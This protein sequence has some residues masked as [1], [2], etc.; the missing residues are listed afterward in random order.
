MDSTHNLN[1]DRI[2][3]AWATLRAHSDSGNALHPEAYRL[4]FADPEFLT[5]RETRGVR[6]QLEMLK[7]DL[8][9]DAQR[10]QNTIVVY[11][12]ARFLPPDEAAALLAAAETAGDAEAIA[13]AQLKV[14][15][16]RYYEQ[17]RL[18]ARLVAT[19]SQA[20]PEDE[21]LYICTGG[22]PGIMEAANRGA[23]EAGA[24][25]VGLNIALPH[26][27]SG[28]RF[29]TPSLSFKFHYFALRKM[30]FMMR[31]K[32]LVAF[33]GGF[34]TLDELFEVLTLVQTGKSKRVPIVLFGKEFWSRLIDF[35]WLVE[36]G[37]ISAADLKLF[38]L[39]DDPQDAWDTI[40]AFYRL[41]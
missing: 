36:E 21:R 23:H 32:A 37:T 19:D 31:A 1:D 16:A 11:G 40:Q 27:Q 18:F 17:A 34:G 39:T 28:N 22:G 38:H 10:I 4:A 41:D 7:P 13:F 6:M 5:R 35:N 2:A 9:Q 14:K 20:R 15:N 8:D 24:L 29:I 33:P 25:N 30:H 12:S 26:E 3:D